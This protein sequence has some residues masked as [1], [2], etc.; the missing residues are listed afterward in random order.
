MNTKR[1][2]Q[3]Q[4]RSILC[5]VCGEGRGRSCKGSRIPG[6]NTLGGGW[7]G[8][9]SLS[10]EHAARIAKARDVLTITAA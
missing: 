5:P 10:R 9:A 2:T 8:P 3:P 6:C 4:R 1:L 7:G